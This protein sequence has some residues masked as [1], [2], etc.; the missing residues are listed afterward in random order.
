MHG[1]FA[2]NTDS[3]YLDA[4]PKGIRAFPCFIE[5]PGNISIVG[6]VYRIPVGYDTLIR[7]HVYSSGD[8][9]YGGRVASVKSPYAPYEQRFKHLMRAAHADYTKTLPKVAKAWTH[10]N[11]DLLVEWLECD[12][13]A[14][15][16]L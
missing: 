12:L 10:K 7:D 4:Q 11:M 5:P 16:V 14:K 3:I 9:S 13:H 1:A 8:Y 15:Q 2:L 6:V